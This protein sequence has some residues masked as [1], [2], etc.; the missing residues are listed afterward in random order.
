MSFLKLWRQSPSDG[1][2]IGRAESGTYD[3]QI[4]AVGVNES[5]KLT[6]QPLALKAK[7]FRPRAE[8]SG[9]LALSTYCVDQLTEEQCWELLELH[10]RPAV[11]ARSE[12]ETR[13]FSDAGLVVDPDWIPERH[14]NVVG[15]PVEDEVIASIT[16]EVLFRAQRPIPRP[17]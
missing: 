9:R 8:P 4:V 1:L 10:V 16:H 6:K 5:G 15:W 12:L 14:V 3:P 7:H 11:V 2:E 17:A 13:V